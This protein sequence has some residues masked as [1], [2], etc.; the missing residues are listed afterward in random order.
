MK[1]KQYLDHLES[2]VF[3]N[4]HGKKR[5]KKTNA[6]FYGHLPRFLAQLEM[7][8]THL[9]SKKITKVY[10]FGTPIPFVSYYFYLTQ[11]AEV[12]YGM[13]KEGI[14]SINE[15]VHYSSINLC[16]PPESFEKADLII[17]TECLEHIPCPLIPVVEF[18]KNLVKKDKYLLLSFPFGTET[19]YDWDHDFGNHE[20]RHGHLREFNKELARTFIKRIGWKIIDD[21]L[22]L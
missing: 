22:V 18:L 11:S 6:Y 10:D 13:P 8:R 20:K 3:R 7:F 1:D 2:E 14:K 16:N 19:K 5:F 4:R 17:C 15:K 21:K 9:D 12:A